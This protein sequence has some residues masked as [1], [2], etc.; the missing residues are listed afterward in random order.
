MT[1]PS[2]YEGYYLSAVE[3]SGEFHGEE[4]EIFS[5]P[6]GGNQVWV[7]DTVMFHILG[8]LHA[9]RACMLSFHLGKT[10]SLRL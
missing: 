8:Q 7:G 4:N 10:F 3:E 5:F 2:P 6:V 1:S 9:L